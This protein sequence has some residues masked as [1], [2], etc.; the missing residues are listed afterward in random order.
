MQLILSI[1]K[2]LT[3][4]HELTHHFV[5]LEANVLFGVPL[6]KTKQFKIH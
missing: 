6:G 2:Q 5:S 3:Q 4:V 1:L